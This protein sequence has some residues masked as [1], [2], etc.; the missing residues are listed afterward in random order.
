MADHGTG[1]AAEAGESGHD[2]GV[3]REFPIAVDFR[4]VLEEESNEIERVGALGVA[5]HER[6]LPRR[7][8]RVNFFGDFGKLPLQ[9]FDLR[10]VSL[11]RRQLIDLAPQ[12]NDGFVELRGIGAHGR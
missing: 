11:P 10:R 12:S 2:R 6:L 7:Q 4:P 5:S 3:I 9:F 8:V 1:R